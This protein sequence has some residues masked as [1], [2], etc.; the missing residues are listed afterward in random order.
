LRPPRLRTLETEAEE[1]SATWTELF[2]DLVFV[3]AVATLGHRFLLDVQ[4]QDLTLRGFVEYAGLF[5]VLWWGWASFTFFADRY[6]TDDP[7]QRLLAVSQMVAVAGMAA[8]FGFGDYTLD[9]I[10]RPFAVAYIGM[11]IA[12]LAMYARAWWNVELSRKLVSGYLQGFSLDVVVWIISIFVPPPWRYVLWVVGMVISFTTI[13]AVR[14]EQVHIP[15]SVS[16]L[17]ERFGLFTIL[18]LG[19]SIA[20]IVAGLTE[21]EWQ[22]GATAGA[23]AGVMMATSLWWVYFDNLEGSVVRRDPNRVH[24]WHPT[25]WIYSHLPLAIMLTMA[26]IGAE[27]LVAA[28]AGHEFESSLRWV[29]VIGVSGAYLAMAMILTSSTSSNPNAQFSRKA[30]LRVA[31]AVAV[32]LLGLAGGQLRPAAFVIILAAITVAEVLL[33]LLV[34][35]MAE[36]QAAHTASV[37]PTES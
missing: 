28:A 26:G 24:D 32:V 25:A 8:A 33:D 14:K 6:D 16:H 29:S 34:D 17:P 37:E 30:L 3:V 1:R 31:A 11:R 15:L 18:V 23:V 35:V 19:E 7:I 2:Y 13:W 20:A 21:E 22:F 27:E 12:L 9:T 5:T 36:R 10:S 4:A